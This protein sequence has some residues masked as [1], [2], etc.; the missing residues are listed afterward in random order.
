M[1][2]YIVPM[3][4]SQFFHV[5][6]PVTGAG[7]TWVGAYPYIDTADLGASYGEINNTITGDPGGQWVGYVIPAYTA[8]AGVTGARVDLQINMPTL[9]SVSHGWQWKLVCGDVTAPWDWSSHTYPPA[10]VGWNTIADTYTFDPAYG[11][12]YDIPA[13]LAALATG[14]MMLIAHQAQIGV[15]FQ[16]SQLRLT[17]IGPDLGPNLSGQLLDDR[18]RFWG[19]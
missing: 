11:P 17:L 6:T 8:P 9:D 1:T 16:V 4:T 10:V 15:T 14:N 18:V 13:M 5:A 3:G 12:D 7:Y 2:E 19:S